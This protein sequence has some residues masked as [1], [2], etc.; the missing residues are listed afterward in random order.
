MIPDEET[1]DVRNT[2]SYRQIRTLNRRFAFSFTA[3]GATFV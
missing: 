2:S 3:P 1:Y